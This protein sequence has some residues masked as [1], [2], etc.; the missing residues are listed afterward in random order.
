MADNV[1]RVIFLDKISSED[2]SLVGGKAMS[3]SEMI[4]A[5]MNVPPGFSITTNVYNSGLNSEIENQIL[6]A[7]DKLGADRVAVRSSA[8]AEDSKSASWAGQ[9]ETYL[10]VNKSELIDAV[11][12]C[13]DSVNSE[14]A[15][16][17]ASQN[18]VSEADKSVG[19]VVQKMVDSDVSGVMFTANPVSNN[20]DEIVLEAIYGLG[21]LIVQGAVTPENL[22]INKK[23]GRVVG[24]SSSRQAKML[25]Y[26]NGKNEEVEV[27]DNKLNRSILSEAEIKELTDTAIRIEKHYGIPQ[28][29]EW[30]IENGKLY[31]TQSRPITTL[32]LNETEASLE[33]E[34]LSQNGDD[35]V[36]RFEGDFMPFQ[37]MIEWWN[38][39]DSTKK[40]EGIYPV[41]FF[42]TPERTTGYISQ[43]KYRNVA[44]KTFSELI[45]GNRSFQEITDNYDKIA[46]K[47]SEDYTK[48]FVNDKRFSSEADAFRT[49]KTVHEDFHELVAWTLF[50]EQ[51]DESAVAE[52]LSKKNVDLERLWEIVKLSVFT[53]IDTRRKEYMLAALEG[54]LQAKELCFSFSDYTFFADEKFVTDELAKTSTDELKAELTNVHEAI[55]R[56]RQKSSDYLK[57]ADELTRIAAEILGWVLQNRDE[58]KDI[59]NKIEL[60]L[61]HIAE[62]LF[63][64]WDMDKDLLPYTGISDILQG[65]EYAKSIETDLPKRKDGF[66]VLY[67]TDRTSI[68]G[69]EDLSAQMKSLDSFI[70]SQHQDKSG[71]IIKGDIGNTGKASGKAR[72]VLKRKEFENFQEGEVLVVGMTRPEYVPLMKKAS[73]IVTD[74]GGITSHAAIVSR[75]LNKPSI[76]GTRIATQIIKTGDIIEVDANSGIVTIL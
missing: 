47:I 4:K 25:V 13:W 42:F 24:S 35:Q 10:N 67:Q 43:D 12:K 38:Q 14:H 19:V 72:I 17:Y 21:E 73:A 37:L 26:K 58:R 59:I 66:A 9:L 22:I 7:F 62:Q 32:G 31:I 6:K 28:D 51:L 68:C 54:N 74:E 40:L 60:I 53:T 44:I 41:L 36:M 69:Y 18:K 56:A 11:K 8:V 61:F 3:L 1:N 49:Y 63:D 34:F 16:E 33:Q 27:P 50:Y 70:L 75:E 5:G 30:A 2:L 45:S 65:R 46:A 55:N 57:N 23:T 76:I 71:H 29:I 52:V 64:F 15:K 20:L 39:Y 48:Y